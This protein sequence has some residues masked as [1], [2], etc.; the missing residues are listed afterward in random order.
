MIFDTNVLIYLSKNA[1]DP[2]RILKDEIA[3]SVITKIE[4]LGFSFKNND[5]HEL[6]LA[7]CSEL[8]VIPLTDLIVEETIFLRKNYR[9]KLPD[10]IIYAT[11]LVENVPLL[12]NNIDDFKSIDRDVKLINPFD[13]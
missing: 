9:I 3:I 6:L 5:E 2:E 1:L 13:L 11:A 10:A 7:I 8:N 12:T 4:V